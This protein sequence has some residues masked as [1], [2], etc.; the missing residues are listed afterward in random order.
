M[1][2]NASKL[3]LYINKWPTANKSEFQWKVTDPC[4]ELDAFT[5]NNFLVEILIYRYVG[6]SF[7][8]IISSSR[9]AIL[10]VGLYFIFSWGPNI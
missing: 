8:V 4:P 7:T 10:F 1:E 6:I 3:L 2:I 9:N 5:P